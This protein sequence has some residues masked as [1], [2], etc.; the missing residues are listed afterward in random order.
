M[1]MINKLAEAMFCD[2]VRVVKEHDAAIGP[3]LQS[4]IVAAGLFLAQAEAHAHH[5]S[6]HQI[7]DIDVDFQ[8]EEIKAAYAHYRGKVNW[9]RTILERGN[10][11]E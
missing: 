4:F 8:L 11:H 3:S 9:F 7:D 5:A 10:V 2:M 6:D 1:D